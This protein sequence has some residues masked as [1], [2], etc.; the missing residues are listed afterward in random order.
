VHA[1]S[2][3]S[4]AYEVT[5]S[6]AKGDLQDCSCD[7]N[8]RSRSTK[9]QWQWGGCSEVRMHLMMTISVQ[10][11]RNQTVRA[12]FLFEKQCFDGHKKCG[13]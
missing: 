4:L 8:V 5:K 13:F 7:E 6:C 3:A 2:A 12:F 9:G 11:N 1:I 10:I